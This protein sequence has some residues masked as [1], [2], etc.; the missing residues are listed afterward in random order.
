MVNAV[1]TFTQKFKE[2][3]WAGSRLGVITF[4][5]D[6]VWQ[7][8]LSEDLSVNLGDDSYQDPGGTYLNKALD[9]AT[10]GNLPHRRVVLTITDGVPTKEN[11]ATNSA[12]AARAKARLSMVAIGVSQDA[13]Y[14]RSIV[15][16]PRDQNYYP[17]E[18]FEGLSDEFVNQLTRDVCETRS[19]TPTPTP[20]PTPAPTPPPTECDRDTRGRCAEY[21]GLCFSNTRGDTYCNRETGTCHCSL[22]DECAFNRSVVATK[23]GYWG[24]CRKNVNETR[25]E[26]NVLH[27]SWL[28][29]KDIAE[30]YGK[31][32]TGSDD[33]DDNANSSMLSAAEQ[34]HLDQLLHGVV[35]CLYV[36]LFLQHLL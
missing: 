5:S 15:S 19:P 22:P 8:P 7:K 27:W 18:S 30:S 23:G 2:R 17:I 24:V 16:E 13:A 10:Q 28:V 35:A 12:T 32:F 21:G 20:S 11:E 6:A 25:G 29:A 3:A 34:P 4:S 36:S 9:L 26:D 14:M 33:Y 1:N 31:A